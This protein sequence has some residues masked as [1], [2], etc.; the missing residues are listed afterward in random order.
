ME[1]CK[2]TVAKLTE[3]AAVAEEELISYNSEIGK[4]VRGQSTWDAA[5]Y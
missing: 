1:R 3:A 4:A 2:A 5:L